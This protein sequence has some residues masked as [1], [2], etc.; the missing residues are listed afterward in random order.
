MITILGAGGV[1]SNELEGE[2]VK[3]KWEH[4]ATVDFMVGLPGT[5][6]GGR[7]SLTAVACELRGGQ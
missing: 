5:L 2:Q 6:S 7:P 3:S 4:T 1:I